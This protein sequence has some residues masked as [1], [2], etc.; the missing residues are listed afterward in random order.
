MPRLRWN[1]FLNKHSG[2]ACI[3]FGFIDYAALQASVRKARAKG[4]RII[5]TGKTLPTPNAVIT[6]MAADKVT[7]DYTISAKG[8]L[9]TLLFANSEEAKH[10]AKALK[11]VLKSTT[12]DRPCTIPYQVPVNRDG[13]I[14]LATEYGLY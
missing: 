12:P 10:F 8:A 11:A 9:Q 3:E 14:A 13:H 2:G 6:K 1:D 5:K 4:Q 7:G